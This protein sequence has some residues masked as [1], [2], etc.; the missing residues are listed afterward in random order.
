MVKDSVDGGAVV[1]GRVYIDEGAEI[2]GD[3]VIREPVYIGRNTLV[4]SGA[5]IGPYT[6]IGDGCYISGVELEDS[7]VMKDV[8]IKDVNARIVGSVIGAHAV[9]ER[10]RSFPSGIKLVVGERVKI[11]V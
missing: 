11:Y 8:T 2:R 6:S 10:K 5:Y 1:E 3:A 4:E 9:I 7:V